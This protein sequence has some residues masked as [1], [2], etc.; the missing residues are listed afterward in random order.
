M[1]DL[2]LLTVTEVAARLR[3]SRPTVYK[4]INEGTLPRVEL[5]RRRMIPAI[6]ITRRIEAALRAAGVPF[7]HNPNMEATL[8][9]A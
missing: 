1:D 8:A 3:I 7:P 9:T 4:M 2:E 6:A 5:G